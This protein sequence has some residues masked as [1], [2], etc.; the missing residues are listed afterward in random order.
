MVGSSNL[1]S[2]FSKSTELFPACERDL[3]PPR[4]A[5]SV[6]PPSGRCFPRPPRP[7]RTGARSLSFARAH[8]E[9][10]P[11]P[12]SNVPFVGDTPLSFWH[13]PF[14]P[15]RSRFLRP[16]GLFRIPISSPALYRRAAALHFS[17]RTRLDILQSSA[18]SVLAPLFPLFRLARFS[19]TPLGAF[20][21]P[22]QQYNTRLLLIRE[23][24]SC[25]RESRRA[26][27]NCSLLV[28]QRPPVTPGTSRSDTFHVVSVFAGLPESR[29]LR[30]V[31]SFLGLDVLH[32]LCFARRLLSGFP[33]MRLPPPPPPFLVAFLRSA[34][35]GDVPFP[36]LFVVQA[37]EALLCPSCEQTR[38][39]FFA[40]LSSFL[41]S[42]AGNGHEGYTGGG[43]FNSDWEGR[44]FFFLLRHRPLPPPFF[45]SLPLLHN[46]FLVLDV[47]DLSFSFEEAQPAN[48]LLK[49]QHPLPT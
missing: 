5:L 23:D 31:Q 13:S 14:T 36:F 15:L 44:Q 26:S 2:C 38:F 12:I 43:V 41:A 8:R 16:P 42:P 48:P 22:L 35:L 39:T 33:G 18:R 25:L 11:P 27:L 29:V 19:S 3:H 6:P 49:L 47:R 46:S 7:N 45:P 30:N 10:P 20:P 40:K 1:D 24:C 28:G 17:L 37:L 34:E 9:R 21:P 4:T 32:S